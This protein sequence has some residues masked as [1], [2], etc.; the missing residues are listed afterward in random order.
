M[1][2]RYPRP[3]DYPCAGVQLSVDTIENIHK[4]R[5][6]LYWNDVHPEPAGWRVALL[7]IWMLVQANVF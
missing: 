6:C 1:S 2:S 3:K 4:L 5:I 7:C